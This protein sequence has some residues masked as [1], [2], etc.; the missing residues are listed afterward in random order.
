MHG[1]INV[2]FTLYV[3][4]FFSEEFY[5]PFKRAVEPILVLYVLDI[6]IYMAGHDTVM[7]PSNVCKRFGV[8]SILTL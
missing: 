5:S 7:K 1:A 8:S 6:P 3:S 4:R 2:K